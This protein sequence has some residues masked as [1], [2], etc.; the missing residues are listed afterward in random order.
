MI[1]DSDESLEKA[2]RALDKLIDRFIYHPDVTL[3]DAAY[4]PHETDENREELVLRIFL[5]NRVESYS[6]LVGFP[7]D[8]DGIPV[9][10]KHGNFGL[11]TNDPGTA[12]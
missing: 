10:L 4:R 3:I 8:V 7:S 5:R 1:P 11:E 12:E 6:P 2:Q 9:I